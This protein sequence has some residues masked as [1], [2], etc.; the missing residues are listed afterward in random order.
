MIAFK[1]SYTI[2]MKNKFTLHFTLLFIICSFLSIFSTTSL[3]ANNNINTYS[4]HCILMET[5][6]GKI[7]Y[8]KDAYSKVY[9]A[10]TTKIMTAILAL[11]KCDL[12]D[13]ATVSHN[14]IYSIPYGYSHAY[15]V[16]GEELTI[17]QLLHVL[18]IPSANDAAVVLAEHIAGSV[19]SFSSMMNT[20]AIELGCK[21]T[22]FV[23]PNGIHSENH[24]STAYDLALIGTYAMQNETFRE[25]VKTTTYTLPAT[26]KYLEAN[27][28]FK[29]TNELI[30]PDDR[31]SVDNYYYQFA[32]GIKTGYTNPAGE[33]LVASAKKDGLE[34]VAVI[35]GAGRTENGLSARFIDCK[36]LFNYAFEN[37]K[38]YTINEENA[39]LKQL[40][41]S[42]ANIFNK[43]LNVKIKDKITLLIKN[44]TDIN[45]ITPT[46]NISTDLKAPIKENSLIGKIEYTIDGN[47]YTSD[48]IAGNNV[49]ESNLRN[50]VL[51][52]ISILLVLLLL[53]K[54]L[55]IKPR[56]SSK[57]ISKKNSKK[58]LKNK[59]DNNF[60]YW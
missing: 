18:L 11:E 49:Y 9:P 44:D 23:N 57:K 31:D 43:D 20:K 8:E 37:Y 17:N 51:T 39:F 35:L 33:C 7:I 3:G 48:L 6:T 25:I 41:I 4:P 36:N 13:V 42:N 14:A 10:S 2:T 47:T 46:I 45:S 59:D 5:S 21:N 60:L 56:K 16:E 54:L 53:Y 19:E 1:L 40:S 27:R 26:N 32:T 15:L 52:I 29:L 24:Y 12:T 38:T 30:V 34:Y 22:N 28:F 58:N 50:T 55:K